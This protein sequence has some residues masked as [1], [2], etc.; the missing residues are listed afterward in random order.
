M[1]SSD[2]QTTLD[3]SSSDILVAMALGTAMV[4]ALAASQV[5]VALLR[6]R[7]NLG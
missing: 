5:W 6:W 1:M 3:S 4:L 2:A 7:F